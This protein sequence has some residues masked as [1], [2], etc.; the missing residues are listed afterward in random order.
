MELLILNKL[1][2]PVSILEGYTSLI[3][4]KRYYG[5]GDFELYIAADSALLDVL[6]K[7]FFITRSDDESVMIIEKIEI[8]TDIKIYPVNFKIPLFLHKN[9]KKFLWGS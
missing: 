6:Q 1:F 5:Y 7:D 3:W 8:K 9:F 4:T 2:Q